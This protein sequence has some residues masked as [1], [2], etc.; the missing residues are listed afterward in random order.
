MFIYKFPK[1]SFWNVIV[2]FYFISIFFTACTGYL[3]ADSS[4]LYS[5]YTNSNSQITDES[6]ICT[7][8]NNTSYDCRDLTNQTYGSETMTAADYD[9]DGD[10][11]ILAT[12]SS[13]FGISRI[14][15]NDGAGV[16]N[17]ITIPSSSGTAND[18]KANDFD[19]DGDIDVA[20]SYGNQANKICLNDGEANFSCTLFGPSNQIAVR[21][22]V[23]DFNN[24]DNTDIVV[25]RQTY[26]G[27][28]QAG[29]NAICLGDGLGGFNCQDMIS[30]LHYTDDLAVGDFNN[31]SFA[32][33]FFVNIPGSTNVDHSLCL[34]NGLGEFACTSTGI[35]TY[36]QTFDTGVTV[37]DFN[38]DTHLD[39]ALADQ[40][41][42]TTRSRICYGNGMGQFSCSLSLNTGSVSKVDSGDID[43]NGY[44]DLAYISTQVNVKNPVC[45]NSENGFSCTFVDSDTGLNNDVSIVHINNIT[46]NKAP[47]IV[48][49]GNKSIAEGTNI[50]FKILASDF[51]NDSL[52]FTASNLPQ[53]SSF[54][55]GD[56][57]WIP[58]YVQAGTYSITFTASDGVLTDSETINIFVT[59]TNRAPILSSVGNKIIS[60]NQTLS[61]TLSASDSDGD[62]LTYSAL[63]LPNG[64][65]LYGNTFSWTP[66]YAQAGNYENVEFIVADNGSPM[67]LDVELVTITVGDVNRAPVLSNPGPRSVIEG[68]NVSFTINGNDPDSDNIVISSTNLPSGA[69]FD[70]VTGQ[71]NWTPTN[72]QAGVYTPTFTATDNGSPIES[73]SVDV[74]ITV[75][76]DPTP[77]EQAQIIIDTIISFSLPNNVTNSY[78]ANLQ[79]IEPF[80]TAGQ[81]QPALNQL[82]AF[83]IKVNQDYSQ[84][85]ITL[86]QRNQLVSIAQTLINDLQ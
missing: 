57:N 72:S 56:F 36:N 22:D 17:C 76:D 6:R 21:L 44:I 18:S 26:N 58:S 1:L 20:I 47:V 24:D 69:T 86:T 16:F 39:V 15:K 32:D 3:S 71:F 9:S 25:A 31:D 29:Y 64:S 8:I 37:N 2:L 27:N 54:V 60:E 23:A 80:I 40:L 68:N 52:A 73:S 61:L 42:R 35:Q 82:N 70:S 78:M 19:K 77:V 62:S 12:K 28:N 14:C 74:V 55:N 45:Y 83:I 33:V 48:D 49:I 75:G 53:G 5:R 13:P 34:N 79:K 66:T 81:I 11:D 59:N 67:E 50:N 38:N 41:N 51:E 84:N 85:K 7:R 46:Q 10:T 63:N 43:N 30:E 65:T 4:I